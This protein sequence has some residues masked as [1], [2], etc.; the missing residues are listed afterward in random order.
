MENE[1]RG[2]NTSDQKVENPQ[3]DM[4]IIIFVTVGNLDYLGRAETW[5][6]DGTFSVCPSLFYQ[7]YI[8][9]AEAHGPIVPLIFNL[10][11]SKSKR[12]TY[13]GCEIYETAENEEGLVLR[14][15]RTPTL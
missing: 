13:V 5:Y 2:E 11:P 10:L 1:R 8:I 9:H 15:R 7:L 12:H 14:K 6:G 4:L 3:A